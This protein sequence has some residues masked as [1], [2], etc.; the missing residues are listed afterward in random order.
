M[1]FPVGRR[2]TA[3]LF[4][5]AAA[6]LIAAAAPRAAAIDAA[7]ADGRY[8]L[9]TDDVAGEL[10]VFSAQDGLELRRIALVDRS[11]RTGKLGWIIDLPRRKSFLAGFEALP[12]AWE[13]PYGEKADPV[14]DGLVH[15]YRMGEG[16]ADRGPLPVRRIPLDAPL[17]LPTPD[18][19]QIHV[20][21]ADPATPGKLNV[22][23]L[24]VRR[25]VAQVD[26][27][28]QSEASPRAV[29]SPLPAPIRGVA[30]P[31]SEAARLEP[32]TVIAAASRV[33]EDIESVAATVS[34]IERQ[35]AFREVTGNLRDLLRYEPGVSIENGTTRFGLGNLNI[36]GLDG[37][38]VQ[39]TVDGIRLPDSYRVG[40]FSNASRNALGLG[41]LKQVEIVR[42][43]ASAI[44]GSDALAGV[45]A[46]TTLDAAPFLA[47]GKAYGGEAYAGNAGADDSTSVGGA[48]ALAAGTTQI[49]IG[50]ESSDG[51]E[52]KN[53]GTVGGTG[54]PRT[55]PNPQDTH[56]DSQLLKWV[57][58]TDSGWRYTLTAERFYREVMTDVLSLNPQSTK[59]QSL[60]GEDQARRTRY[61]I[62]ALAYGL[63]P[64]TRLSITAYAQQSRTQQETHELRTNTTAVCLT[65]A[66]NVSCLRE[67]LF[68]YDAE[69][70]GVVAIG[71]AE[72][73]WGGLDHRVVFGAE[74]SRIQ[75][76][77]IRDGT[78]T[79]L[80]TGEVTNVVGGEALPTRDFPVTNTDRLGLFVQDSVAWLDP[81]LTWIPGLRFDAF[82]LRPQPDDLFASGNPG[83]PVASLSD[84]AL[85]PKLGLLY[86]ASDAVTFNGQLATGFRAPPAS[87]LNIGL[88]NLPSGYTVIPN[89]DLQPEHSRGAEAGLRL[90]S[91]TVEAMVTAYYTSY[92]D[93]IVSR[94]ALP[95][96]GDP[97]CVPGAT[98][99]FQ[100]QNVS[101]A[102]IYGV[103]AKAAW[104]F[105]KGWT[106][107]AA[108]AIPR[109]DDMSK[110]VPL[111]SI[112]PPQLVAGVGY[113]TSR[114][115]T[116]LHVTHAW[117]QSRV[118]RSTGTRFVPPAWTTADLT[119]W[120]KVLP[121]LEIA[122]GIFNMADAKYWLWSDVRGLANV[123]VGLD[124]YTQPGRNVGIN[125]RW[126]F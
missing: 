121:T 92:D 98:G 24:D 31:A 22:L 110:D 119:T 9:A 49:L 45:V 12:E 47:S 15:D 109:G 38:R 13:L 8:R 65:A 37:N 50:A 33:E 29:A 89:P 36:R 48:L 82:R 32:V 83:R 20:A 81:R 80:N 91:G 26:A 41:L 7:S 61:S 27:P 111:N 43:P 114:W 40:S 106:A 122:A 93:L 19:K 84:Q 123:T 103:E 10:V 1:Q 79:N 95:C 60:T 125:A 88:T 108:F 96:P 55:E 71:Q 66:G 63:G 101:S 46:F 117:E 25:I 62:E 97:G 23:N 6:S 105:S 76:T 112:D 102:R 87:D 18:E 28:A 113:E 115:G 100:S 86:R 99:T 39:M 77:E 34:V 52:M 53:Q 5:S 56:Q 75:T 21:W 126:S 42:G 67:P 17:P 73:R 120:V 35:E 44:H 16:I 94:A 58:P 69:E 104:R 64:A 74:L 72:P 78:Q 85:S 116:S 14:F 68:R 107:R 30:R 124:R 4:I 70:A 59:T 51:H 90:K 118:D 11:R 57:I 2:F 54:A 3:G